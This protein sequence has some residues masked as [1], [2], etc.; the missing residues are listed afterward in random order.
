MFLKIEENFIINT[1]Y[2]ITVHHDLADKGLWTLVIKMHDGKVYTYDFTDK[3]ECMKKF[4][5]I[6][7]QTHRSLMRNDE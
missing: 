5:Q 2:I 1:D 3:K 7:M 4:E 6:Y